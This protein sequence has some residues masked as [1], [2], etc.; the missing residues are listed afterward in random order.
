MMLGYDMPDIH[1]RLVVRCP[2]LDKDCVL[3]V[4]V[5]EPEAMNALVVLVHMRNDAAAWVAA[6]RW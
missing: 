1:H 6:G 3:P 5:R 2:S 4:W